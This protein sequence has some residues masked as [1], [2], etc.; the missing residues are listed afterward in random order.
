LVQL[1]ALAL[2]HKAQQQPDTLVQIQHPDCEPLL[3][4]LLL[5]WKPT[6]NL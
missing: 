4:L 5:L 1:A 2:Q 3:L 6:R